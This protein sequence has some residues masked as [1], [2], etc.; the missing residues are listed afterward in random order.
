MVN[1]HFRVLVRLHAAA[2]LLAIQASSLAFRCL[3]GG[4]AVVTVTIDDTDEVTMTMAQGAQDG[5]GKKKRCRKRNHT[6][7]ASRKH[8]RR[9]A[10]FTATHGGNPG[11]DSD[12][13]EE[14]SAGECGEWRRG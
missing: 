11:P 6:A 5:T 3:A 1:N 10:G 9:M 12:P 8:R 7:R 13:D 4:Y 2:G 14:H